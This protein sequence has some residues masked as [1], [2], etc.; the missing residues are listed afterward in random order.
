[1]P[2]GRV[3][4]CG[5]YHM[6]SP[7][8]PVPCRSAADL[9]AG[10]VAEISTRRGPTP[11]ILLVGCHSP[12]KLPALFLQ[13]G[14]PPCSEIATIPYGPRAGSMASQALAFDCRPL[15]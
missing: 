4:V 8:R 12:E 2:L 15:E 7:G 10:S 3:G 13:I 5:G 14:L 9:S 1:M 11:C 6:S